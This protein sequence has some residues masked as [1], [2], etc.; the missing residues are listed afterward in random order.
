MVYAA[1]P[2]TGSDVCLP[3]R[4]TVVCDLKEMLIRSAL[5]ERAELRHVRTN[6]D[7]VECAVDFV[8]NFLATG[9]K[10]YFQANGANVIGKPEK[11]LQI[12]ALAQEQKAI[13]SVIITDERVNDLVRQFFTDIHPQERRMAP[14]A[15]TLAIA[16]VNCQG[17]SIG[18]LLDD[19]GGHLWNIFYHIWDLSA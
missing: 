11:C 10:R 3:E 6:L 4:A 5:I 19:H 2:E 17:N 1:M 16:Y 8:L 9:I 15:I 18:Y 12:I 7:I 13:N 14:L